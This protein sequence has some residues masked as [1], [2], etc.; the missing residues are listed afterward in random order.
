MKKLIPI[1]AL[2]FIATGT[3]VLAHTSAMATTTPEVMIGGAGH[4]LVRGATV[5]AVSLP[6]ITA[7]TVWGG[8]TLTWNLTNIATTTQVMVGDTISFAGALTAG[9]SLSVAVTALKDVTGTTTKSHADGD[10]DNE[11]HEKKWDTGLRGWLSHPGF[12]L[13]RFK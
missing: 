5:T 8:T 4:V 1:L 7:S 2:A 6:L 10:T 12:H 3:P 11:K 13:G 9:N